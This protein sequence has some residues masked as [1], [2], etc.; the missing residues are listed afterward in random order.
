M[1][2]RKPLGEA[3]IDA[4]VLFL[5][6]DGEREDFLFGE[7]GKAFHGGPA[8]EWHR[9]LIYIRSILN[10]KSGLLTSRQSIG[11]TVDEPAGERGRAM[12]RMQFRRCAPRAASRASGACCT[13]IGASRAA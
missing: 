10:K 3:A 13:S 2:S 12:K 6:G 5:V 7:I 8:I 11:V 1:C 9:V 4:A